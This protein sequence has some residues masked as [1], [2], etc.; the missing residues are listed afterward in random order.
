MA[1]FTVKDRYILV[2][3]ASSGIGKAICE[4][5]AEAG[6]K[7]LACA[8]K[9][10][11]ILTLSNIK[12]VLGLRLDVTYAEE[13][14]NI[15]KYLNSQRIQLYGI[16]N[17]AGIAVG[18]P[19]LLLPENELRDC[20]EVN[21]IAPVNI[22]RKLY[23]FMEDD[24]IIVN[25]SSMGARYITP[26]MAPYHMS[27]V[28][29]EAYTEALRMELMPFGIRV[30]IIEPGAVQTAAF[31][32]WDRLLKHMR[33][34]VYEDA[35]NTY[36]KMITTQHTRALCPLAIAKVVLKVVENPR[37][38]K[39][40]LIP[41]HPFVRIVILMAMLGWSDMVYRRYLCKVPIVPPSAFQPNTEN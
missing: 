31:N 5:L 39:R 38:R 41:H 27:K 24:G 29:L 15:V 2:T 14:Q 19:M 32:K 30:V 10:E 40:Y 28:A 8:R 33:G 7:I 13:I 22:I 18:G 6:A 4:T 34:T 35:F 1:V 20:L 17:N 3:G 21:T 25:I 26:W 23:P 36:W 11:D 9:S 16:I 12:N 37:P